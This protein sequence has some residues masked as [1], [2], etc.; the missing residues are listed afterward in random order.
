M[1]APSLK[2]RCECSDGFAGLPELD[3]SGCFETRLDVKEGQLVATAADLALDVGGSGTILSLSAMADAMDEGTLSTDQRISAVEDAIDA[4]GADT[5]DRVADDIASLS[6]TLQTELED[7]TAS[8]AAAPDADDL[9]GCARHAGGVGRG[10][11]RYSSPNALL[12]PPSSRSASMMSST[13]RR[14]CRQWPLLPRTTWRL[15]LRAPLAPRQRCERVHFAGR[16]R[17]LQR[18]VTATPPSHLALLFFSDVRQLST[19][20]SELSQIAS[21]N[22]D[23]IATLRND[24]GND[25]GAAARSVAHVGRL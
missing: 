10:V 18:T 25:G 17:A 22:E 6:T 14:A 20:V 13:R 24:L 19:T 3:G 16:R 15:R 8:V 11:T 23:D 5:L 21:L 9:V 1:P 7:L 4:I 2:H 12:L